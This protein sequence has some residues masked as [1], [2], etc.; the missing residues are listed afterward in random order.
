MIPRGGLQATLVRFAIRFRGAVIGLGVL[1][2]AAGVTSVRHAKYDVFPEFAPPQATI[3]AEAPGLT[4]EQVELLVTQPIENALNGAPGLQSLRSAS[5]QGLSLITATFDP[6]SDVYGDRQVIAERLSAVAGQLPRQVGPPSMTPL[7]SS[8]STALVVGLTSTARSPMELRAIAEWTIRPRLLAL[9]GVAKV[10]IFGSGARSIRVAVHPDALVRYRVALGDVLAAAQRAAGISGAGF[11]DTPNQRIVLQ[12]HG[13]PPDPRRIAATPLA[14]GG[15]ADGPV[16]TGLTIGDVASVVVAPE[17]ATGGAATEGREGIQLVVSQ[18]YGANTVEVTRRVEA[19]LEDLRPALEREGI[20]LHADLFRPANFI[21]AATSNVWVALA[22]GAVLVVVVLALFLFD[23]RIAAISSIAI[24]LSLLAALLV[25]QAFGVSVNT[26]TLGGLAVSIGVVVD[27]AVIDIENI[28]RRLRE[29]R[30]L[31]SPRPAAR[32]ILD[33]CLEVRSAV[34]YATFAIVLVV[35]PVLTL[36]GLAGQLFGPLAAAFVLA[37]LASL[38]VSL[39]VIPALAALLLSGPRLAHRD[40]P[41]VRWTRQRYERLLVRLLPHPRAVL[42]ATV[43][44][45]IGGAALL[46]RF[47]ATFIPELREGHF[48]LHMSAVPGTSIAES[49]RLGA[50]VAQALHRIPAVRSIAQ[51]VGRAEM[52]DDVLGTHYSEF[53]VDLKP[54]AGQEIDAA[55]A[56]IRAALDDFPGVGFSLQTFL[57]ER[58]EET[59]SGYTAPVVINLYGPDLDRLDREAAHVARI[60]AQVP[61][62][63][64]V[65]VQSP[66][67]A[68][69]LTI[70]VRG[71]ACRR[72]GLAQADVLDAVRVAYQGETAAQV[73]EG[74]R[75]LAVVVALDDDARGRVERVGALPLRTPGGAMV[76]LRDVADIEQESGR[77]EVLHQGAQRLQTVT[78]D[79]AGRDLESFVGEVRQRVAADVHLPVG[80]YVDFA[81]AAQAASQSRHDLLY[82]SALAIVGIVV[83]VSFI[84][85]SANNLLLVLANLPFAFVG[86]VVAVFLEGGV[87]SLGSMVGFVALFGITLRNSIL[88]VARYE[89]MV[90]REHARWGPDAARQGAADRLA[91]ILMTSLVTALGLLPLVVG[92]EEAGREIQGAMARVILGG[93]LTSMLLNLLVLPTLALHFGRFIPRNDELGD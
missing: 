68:P 23:L 60:V 53:D 86:G 88:I 41:P 87:L 45:T 19:A 28:V 64:D 80:T 17:P 47:G 4:P 21:D 92:S 37:I 82:A 89:D 34:V 38:L 58:I 9:R 59:L 27:D 55:Q 11:V 39:T 33:A 29:N 54:L 16:V 18:Q 42:A 69:Q 1:L 25:L 52:A 93:L 49:L 78:A 62:A 71:D 74:N 90:T 31:A 40:P 76:A 12:T 50:E 7:T 32:V 73:F 26:M 6:S 30:A 2:L 81:G 14:A 43:V 63:R 85:G 51:R 3:Q 65:Q 70:R 67:G 83:L 56:Q 46:A 36:G 75:P 66:P 35:A 72:W 24:P 79:V 61:G 84:T 13:T 77:D 22:I 8:T 91:P 48:I 20:E 10:P 15:A 5:I 57:T 44:A